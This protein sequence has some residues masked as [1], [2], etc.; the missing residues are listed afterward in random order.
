[1]TNKYIQD[2]NYK[3][4]QIRI[5]LETQD[6]DGILITKQSNFSWITHGRAYVGLAT[7]VACANLLVM[8]NTVYLVA[9]DIEKYR[10]LNEELNNL[11]ECIILIN[12]PW[13]EE[14]KKFDLIENLIG[15]DKF[16]L[17][18]EYES[19]FAI[20]RSTLSE[21]DIEFLRD[22]SIRTAHIVEETCRQLCKGMT[23]Y[24]IAGLV[25]AKLWKEGIEPVTVLI[26][27]DERISNYRHPI[28]SH[29]S[30][31]NYAMV[32]VNA[33]KWGLFS[34]VTRFVSLTELSLELEDKFNALAIIDAAF[35]N[36]TR[37]GEIVGNIIKTAIH[38]YE[39]LGYEGEWKLHHQGGLTGYSAREYK[40]T[41]ESK[42]IIQE[43]QAFAWNPTIT[44]TKAE[45]TILIGKDK[46]EI[47]TYTGEYVYNKISY[48]GE[49]YNI[50]A[51]FIKNKTY[52]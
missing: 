18:V 24:E 49:N 34:S 22:L 30:L 21:L 20:F 13:Y 26:G 8:K 28:P 47:L 6:L 48:K 25:S 37:P 11:E 40:A 10:L 52:N 39:E 41:A 43:N 42:E 19:E 31:N 45:D 46:N 5:L 44:G 38:K 15:S 29:N 7:E 32:A 23:E 16:R 1:M 50:P 35:I 9:N 14:N 12:Y 3:I 51:V 17:D 27:C 36:Q 33:R 2:F 4:N